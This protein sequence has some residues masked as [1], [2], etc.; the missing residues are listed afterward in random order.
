MKEPLKV[1][2]AG[3][4]NSGKSSLFNRLTGL[5]QKVGNYPGVTVEQHSGRMSMPQG[6]SAELVDL[7]G[8]YSLFPETEDEQVA[9]QLLMEQIW[10]SP[11]TSA[12]T[13]VVVVADASSLRRNLLLIT[14]LSD[15]N[16]PCILVLNKSDLADAAG[17]HIDVP[18]LS[19]AL[20]MPVVATNAR[21]GEG[22]N[23]LKQALLQAPPAHRYP[24]FSD[25]PEVQRQISTLAQAEGRPAEYRDFV[26]LMCHERLP[27]SCANWAHQCRALAESAPLDRGKIRAAETVRRYERI[28]GLMKH[29]RRDPGTVNRKATSA[30]IDRWL[31]HPIGGY[32]ILFALL[33]FMFQAIFSWATLPMELIE[34]LFG[35]M[36]GLTSD[37]LPQGW[38]SRM[39]V[40]GLLAGLSGVLVFIPQIS[41]L[42]FF[43]GVL[44]E[45]GYMSRVSFLTDRLM[46]SV[47]LN[48]RS[49]MP[50]IGGFACA[51][52]SIMATRSIN[53][54]KERLLT[55]LVLPLMSCSARLP[56]YTLLIS[57]CV[58][59][60]QW[61]G[62]FNVQGLV[63]MGLYILGL[64]TAIAAALV[65][66]WFIKTRETSFFML[67]M[68]LY[69]WPVWRNVG[70]VV[71]QRLQG[72]VME[73][74]KVIVVISLILWVL[75]NFGPGHRMESLRK[76]LDAQTALGTASA[77]DRAQKSRIE[78]ELLAASWAG[79]AGKFLEPAIEPLGF[80]WKIGIALVTSFAAREV[81]V[82]TMATMYSLG[83][84]DFQVS[85]L[86]GRM[87]SE[88]NPKTGK[89]VYS[90][91]TCFSLL[92][93][94]AFAL[95]CMSTLAVTRRETKT[96]LWPAV[97]FLY[98][99][100]L[101]YL[102]SL[103][104]YTWLS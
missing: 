63:L 20:G 3:N 10:A 13:R 87:L 30:S 82:G 38:F 48:G 49:V 39:L 5:H 41:L 98:M 2:L 59:E 54:R 67:E 83:T 12:A 25:H 11:A 53:N 45:S 8:I 57:I 60:N 66:R 18:A 97:Q 94:Y 7:P 50:L 17:I 96:W 88:V 100:A 70:H 56:V 34:S 58:P 68:P 93:F 61:L 21:T 104:V 85:E 37:I 4:P 35:Y 22:I 71:G 72:F 89:P 79:H 24:W 40:D 47:G 16:L 44:E 42:F 43:L 86:R 101:A 102:G 69:Q 31:L 77:D 90:T 36:G 65:L 80:D 62:V 64:F 29:I 1:W 74:G 15:L 76:E 28:A 73:A 32:A 52:P 26:S 9:F 27:D 84:E 46:Q 23:A 99:G 92:V 14:Q 33:F 6:D 103:L 19:S 75:S 91:A 51:V 55:I 95:Q 78:Q 81:F